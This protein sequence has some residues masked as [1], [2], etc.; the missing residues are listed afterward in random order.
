MGDHSNWTRP[1]VFT[2]ALLGAILLLSRGDA[3]TPQ[4]RVIVGPWISDVVVG[5]GLDV[6]G[7]N[8]RGSVFVGQNLAGAVF[9]HC[10]L[11]GARIEDCNLT[12]ASFRGARLTGAEVAGTLKGADFTD[13]IISGSAVQLSPEQLTSTRSYKTKDLSGCFISATEAGPQAAAE[14]TFREMNLTGANLP[15]DV[16]RFD[17]TDARIAGTEFRGSITFEQLASTADF[18][19]R[20]LS[21]ELG[22]SLDGE[23]DFSRLNLRGA[24]LPLSR[25]VVANFTDAQISDCL[26]GRG[27]TKANLYSTADYK[28]GVI[29]RTVFLHCDFSG[30]DLSGM[31]LIESRFQLCDL[32]GANFEDAV[33][34]RVNFGDGS[35]DQSTGLTADQIKSTWNYKHG[36]IEGITL[37]VYLRE[38]VLNE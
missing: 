9:D 23:A 17:F 38:S 24:R 14:L 19:R 11:Q 10:D 13:A 4:P 25:T 35:F 33:I 5:P 37:P 12:N 18:K 28:R 7:R 27:F 22:R 15:G 1:R 36:R 32:K 29:M 3:D 26:V 6:S 30:V 16:R 20:E 31:C 8:L 34:T 21:C 2:V